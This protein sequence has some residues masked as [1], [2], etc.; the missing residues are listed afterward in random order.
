MRA[1]NMGVELTRASKFA[2][3][4]GSPKRP[5]GATGLVLKGP[6]GPFLS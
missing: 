6:L 2:S 4:S 5:Y 3:F 1:P